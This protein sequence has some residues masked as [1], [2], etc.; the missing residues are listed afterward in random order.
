M[1]LAQRSTMPA[2]WEDVVS[3]NNHSELEWI[4]QLACNAGCS[5][6]P[7][8]CTETLLPDTGERFFS[9][10]LKENRPPQIENDDDRCQCT[11]CTNNPVLLQHL[12]ANLLPSTPTTTTPS[13]LPNAETTTRKEDTNQ[14]NND[15]MT[16]MI[17]R[18]QQQ[19]QQQHAP[20]KIT[21]QQV[22]W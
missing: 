7:Y 11:K 13:E 1:E 6:I 20:P 10:Y 12:A 4:N 5:T 2:D 14:H 21:P 16:P 19:Q 18:Q 3:Y 8:P 15:G 22:C 9:K 17:N